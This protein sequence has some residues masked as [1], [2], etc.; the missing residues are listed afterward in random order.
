MGYG[1]LKEALLFSDPPYHRV[2]QALQP[3]AHG[4]VRRAVGGPASPVTDASSSDLLLNTRVTVWSEA[5][6]AAMAEAMYESIKLK[7][8]STLQ[9]THSNN[10]STFSTPSRFAKGDTGRCEIARCDE[11]VN[12]D[13]RSRPVLCLGSCRV[14]RSPM[15][16]QG[17]VVGDVML[18]EFTL[19]GT[20]YIALNTPG[21]TFTRAVS[22]SVACEN[23]DDT[24]RQGEALTAICGAEIACGWLMDR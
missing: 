15:D 23:Q 10:S 22:F 21:F 19:A 7:L 4:G 16:K 8:R 13:R 20:S 5:V 9:Q 24:G 12:R 14:T 1:V 2:G 11:C 17:D 3:E 6:R 18:I